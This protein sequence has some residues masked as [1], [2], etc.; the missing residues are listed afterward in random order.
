MSGYSA[1]V[2]AH[3]VGIE[4]GVYFLQKPVRARELLAMVHTVLESRRG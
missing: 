3:Q 1:D 2:I 4:P